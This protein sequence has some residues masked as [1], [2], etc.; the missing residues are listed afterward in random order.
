MPKSLDKY[1]LKLCR[2]TTWK[3]GAVQKAI[4]NRLRRN[5]KEYFFL[6]LLDLS[7]LYSRK[8]IV[9]SVVLL[10]Q[11]GIIELVRVL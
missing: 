7:A 5:K 3:C 11:R 2:S 10:A 8:Q 6:V 9:E 1:A 4:I